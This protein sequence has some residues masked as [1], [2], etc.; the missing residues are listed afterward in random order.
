MAC[1]IVSAKV[2]PD[3]GEDN[4][5]RPDRKSLSECRALLGPLFWNIVHQRGITNER[6]KEMLRDYQKKLNSQGRVVKHWNIKNDIEAQLRREDM[7][8]KIFCMGLEAIGATD[9]DL[10]FSVNF[11]S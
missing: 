8:W 2:S 1:V 5:V 11:R 7:T 4:H 9:I 10:E 3:A 6:L